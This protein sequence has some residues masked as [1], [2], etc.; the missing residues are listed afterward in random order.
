MLEMKMKTMIMTI[1]GLRRKRK[2]KKKVD[3][4]QGEKDY[5]KWMSQ[6]KMIQSKGGKEAVAICSIIVNIRANQ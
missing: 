2:Y 4:K 6:L 1:N 3:I 5:Q